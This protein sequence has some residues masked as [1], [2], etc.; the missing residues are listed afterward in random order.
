MSSQGNTARATRARAMPTRH[1]RGAFWDNLHCVDGISR[2]VDRQVGP[3]A[4]LH[5][6]RL[7]GA[8]RKER[9][10]LVWW[11]W[12]LCCKVCAVGFCGGA[13]G[14]TFRRRSAVRSLCCGKSAVSGPF[15]LFTNFARNSPATASNTELWS[16][17]LQRFWMLLN[18]HAV[19]LRATLWSQSTRIVAFVL[20]RIRERVLDRKLSSG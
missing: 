7:G 18:V 2:G 10:V 12:G 19:E 17:E 15:L 6:E 8:V 13:C 4:Y 3:S 11:P 5:P 14:A 9:C 1:H 16:L 20:A